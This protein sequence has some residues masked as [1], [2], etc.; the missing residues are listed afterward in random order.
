[1]TLWFGC[2]RLR[3]VR[4]E[5]HAWALGGSCGTGLSAGSGKE[6]ERKLRGEHAGL[7][8][9]LVAGLHVAKT[10][11]GK[12]L[13]ERRNRPGQAYV[14]RVSLQPRAC[15]HRLGVLLRVRARV[16]VCAREHTHSKRVCVCWPG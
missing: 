11:A 13:G 1:M 10:K 9:L 16:C 4:K 15:R 2:N 12:K 14:R 8:W 6:G 7:H 5:P 3:A